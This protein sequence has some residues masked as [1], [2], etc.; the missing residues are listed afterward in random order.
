MLEGVFGDE[1]GFC[2]AGTWLRNP[3]GSHHQ[4]FSRVGCTILVKTGHLPRTLAVDGSP[5]PALPEG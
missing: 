1:F 5:G 4:P 3:P 2:P